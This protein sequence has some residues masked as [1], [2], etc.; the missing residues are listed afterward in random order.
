MRIDIARRPPG[1]N[2]RAGANRKCLEAKSDYKISDLNARPDY[3]SR[4]WDHF[5]T[6]KVCADAG[7]QAAVAAADR[8]WDEWL[9][10]FLPD[11]EQRRVIPRPYYGTGVRS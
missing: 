11:P 3:V 9:A 6:L 10:G 1:R 8:A 5:A 4:L 7:D 2:R